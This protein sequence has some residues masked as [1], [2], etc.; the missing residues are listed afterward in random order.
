MTMVSSGY[1]TIIPIDNPLEPPT[2]N[3]AYIGVDNLK[4]SA[5]F[6]RIPVEVLI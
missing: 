6:D 2:D 3:L 4:L 5:I 1:I